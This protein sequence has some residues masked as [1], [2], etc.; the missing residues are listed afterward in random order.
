MEKKE[1]NKKNNQGSVIQVDRENGKL[2]IRV[3]KN[4]STTVHQICYNCKEDRFGYV[5]SNRGVG[6]AVISFQFHRNIG[7]LYE[8]LISL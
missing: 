4:G 7:K 8:D 3:D 1:K 6:Q 5:G 2:Y